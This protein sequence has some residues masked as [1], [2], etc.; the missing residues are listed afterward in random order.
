MKVASLETQ[1]AELVAELAQFYGYRTVW[2]GPDGTVCHTEPEM[3]LDGA[4]YTYVATL[5]R[6]DYDAL[7]QTLVGST[8]HES[9]SP[10]SE[11]WMVP[12]DGFA[13]A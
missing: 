6:P 7:L 11:P 12:A 3:E 4:E 5:M 9:R 8:P 13:L 1:V 2:V 10:R